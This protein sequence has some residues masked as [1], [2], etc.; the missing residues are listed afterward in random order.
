MLLE[1][2]L[3]PLSFAPHIVAKILCFFVFVCLMQLLG[4]ILW[5]EKKCS[6]IFSLDNES[7]I[8]IECLLISWFVFCTRSGRNYH[9]K[10]ESLV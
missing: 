7:G 1:R 4:Y 2:S 10:L 3:A 6:M 5:M 8:C 9:N